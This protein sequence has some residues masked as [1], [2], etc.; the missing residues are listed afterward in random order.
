MGVAARSV[1]AALGCLS[2]VSLGGLVAA[3][4]PTSASDRPHL[5]KDVNEAI[6]FLAKWPRISSGQ[7]FFEGATYVGSKSCGGSGCHDTQIAEWEKTWHAKILRDPTKD[8]VKG[9]FSNN[10]PPVSFTNVRAIAK[11]QSGTELGQLHNKPVGVQVKTETKDGKYFFVI[12]DTND[13]SKNQRYEVVKVVGGKWQQTYHVHPVD[14]DGKPTGLYFPAP[15]RW[16]INPN[17]TQEPGGWWELGNFQ[18]ENWVW[19]DHSGA[20][21]PRAPAELPI[22]R[23]GEPKCMG[24]HT[25]GFSF[26]LPD[27]VS[28]WQMTEKEHEQGTGPK[29]KDVG[30]L[31]IGCERCHGPGSKHVA[32]ATQKRDAGSKLDPAKDEIFIVHGLK[33][34]TL[35]QQNQV[36]GQCHARVSNRL[37]DVLAFPYTLT[38]KDAAG[39]IV[40]NTH[41][42]KSGAQVV[43]RG[44]VP[45]DSDLTERGLFWSYFNP[46]PPNT[47]GQGQ[48]TFWPDG[49]GKKSR[50]QWQDHMSSAHATKAGASCMT[51]HAFHG[52]AVSKDP[53]QES[54]LR[55]PP[56]ALCESCHSLSNPTGNMTG[57]THQP[58]KEMYGQGTPAQDKHA[59]QPDQAVTCVDCHMGAVGQRMTQRMTKSGENGSAAYDVSYHGMSIVLPSPT[60]LPGEAK[61]GVLDMRG[62]CDV[63]HTDRRTMRNGDPPPK[64]EQQVLLAYLTMVQAST[65]SAVAAIQKRIG[66][67]KLNDDNTIRLRLR[68]QDNLR[69]VL[70]DRSLGTHNGAAPKKGAPHATGV[71]ERCLSNA[72]K[73][74][75]IACKQAG[76]NCMG[77]PAFPIKGPLAEPNPPICVAAKN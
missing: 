31:A 69:M 9:D 58:N 37:P 1:W 8:I 39:K 47:P 17:K 33:D 67:N 24:C 3:Q 60:T 73:W 32:A 42:G 23:F 44:F 36:C 27:G 40:A 74:T 30:E 28:H 11:D 71:I 62:N 25:T 48:D 5:A 13:A 12:V 77:A 72:N 15:I 22:G 64:K 52:D 57:S 19:S 18:P 20:V 14:K 26:E 59:A 41:K 68:V 43:D 7:E 53:Q 34:L 45:G 63:C 10:S 29:K 50:T 54:K 2:I 51:C 6:E 66:S 35:E 16:S 76:A 49:R 4:P 70:L 38:H 55:Q 65:K 75:E 21:A 46:N 56:Q 61:S